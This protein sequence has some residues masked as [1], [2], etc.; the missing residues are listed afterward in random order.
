MS[1]LLEPN[2]SS[3]SQETLLEANPLGLAWN[4]FVLQ[5]PRLSSDVLEDRACQEPVERQAI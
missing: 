5:R 2:P 3:P 1:H 4:S